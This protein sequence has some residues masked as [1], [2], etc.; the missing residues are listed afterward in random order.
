MR[1]VLVFVGDERII[2]RDLRRRS[3]CLCQMHEGT[4]RDRYL[5]LVS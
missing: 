4:Y 3:L 2:R 1:Y 5:A